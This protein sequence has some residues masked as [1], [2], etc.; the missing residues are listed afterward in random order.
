MYYREIFLL[1]RR[2]GTDDND[3]LAKVIG[4]FVILV[5]VHKL[6]FKVFSSKKC[7]H[8][9][10]TASETNGEYDVIGMENAFTSI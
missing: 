2:A 6:S 4:R 7:R 9:W 3:F 1:T 5:R 8:I 10:Q